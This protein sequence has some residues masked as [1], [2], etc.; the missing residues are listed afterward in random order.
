MCFD[1]THTK[2]SSIYNSFCYE[3]WSP[4]PFHLFGPI[5]LAGQAEK[6]CRMSVS[7]AATIIRTV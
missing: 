3:M 6:C 4:R 2:K 1:S 5:G 7:V